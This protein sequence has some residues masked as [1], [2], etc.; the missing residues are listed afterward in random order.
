MVVSVW[1]SGGGECRGYFKLRFRSEHAVTGSVFLSLN[2]MQLKPQQIQLKMY[3]AINGTFADA[4]SLLRIT[5][6]EC[7]SADHVDWDLSRLRT[8][9][10]DHSATKH[11]SSTFEGYSNKTERSIDHRILDCIIQIQQRFPSINII[12]NEFWL[13]QPHDTSTLI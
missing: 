5:S 11:P 6:C 8:E 4:K 7:R 1:C 2:R 3:L 13:K 10:R 9:Q 12:E